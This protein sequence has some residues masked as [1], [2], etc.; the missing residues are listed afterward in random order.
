MISRSQHRQARLAKVVD[1]GVAV[2]LRFVGTL[3]RAMCLSSAMARAD[4]RRTYVSK[5]GVSGLAGRVNARSP[6]TVT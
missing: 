1:G 4:R 2:C 6:D 3:Y 5:I